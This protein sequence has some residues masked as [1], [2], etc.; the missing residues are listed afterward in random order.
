MRYCP[1]SADSWSTWSEWSKCKNT[2]GSLTFRER[3]CLNRGPIGS[4]TNCS[5][6]YIE[7]D[8][9]T[10]TGISFFLHKIPKL[11]TH[12]YLK[13]AKHYLLCS[14]CFC[15][16]VQC[17]TVTLHGFKTHKTCISIYVLHERKHER[18]TFRPLISKMSHIAFD[19]WKIVD[20]Y[21]VCTRG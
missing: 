20:I 14:L 15:I 7:T 18:W 8:Q 3:S 19:W 10:C 16:Y 11:V 6:G 12:M 17:S 4:A 9:C 21:I 13:K 2:C 5:G 1:F